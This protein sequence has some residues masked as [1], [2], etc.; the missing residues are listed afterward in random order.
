MIEAYVTCIEDG[1]ENPDL[2]DRWENPEKLGG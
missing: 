2:K 1:W